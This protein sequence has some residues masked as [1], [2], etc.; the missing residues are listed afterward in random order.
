MINFGFMK[1]TIK[2]FLVFLSLSVHAQK[3]MLTMHEAVNGLSTELAIK[4][5]N[6]LQWT[7]TSNYYANVITQ[8]NIEA[9]QQSNPNTFDSKIVFDLL[10]LNKAIVN[11]KVDTFSKMPKI[12]WI[13]NNNFYVVQKH[14]YIS[15]T[16]KSLNNLVGS[17]LYTLPDDA[18]N[19]QIHQGS[20]NIAYTH[21]F[22]IF[23]CKK[24]EKAV[25]ITTDG[26]SNLLYGTS[27][28][29]DEFGIDHGLFWSNDGNKI[30]YYKMD[31]SMVTDYP[32]I[33]WSAV[34]AKVKN[35][36]Y[37]FAGNTSHHVT[38]YTYNLT[39]Q[40]NILM[41][42]GEPADQ[43]LTCVTWSPDDANIYIGV[44]NREQNYLKL[45]KY[46][47]DDGVFQKIVVEERNDKYVEP[48]H[49]LYFYNHKNDQF[50]WWSQRD[51]FM[52]LYLVT[53]TNGSAKQITS[54]KWIV[55]DIAGYNALT[56]EILF[57]GTKDGAQEKNVY[58]V[59]L[60]DQ[61]I[62]KLNRNGGWHN[63]V[64]CNDASFV[65]DNYSNVVEPRT[66][67][68][69]ATNTDVEHR[70][71]TAKNTLAD[72][73]LAIVKPVSFKTNDDTKLYG[74]LMLP[75]DFDSKKKYPVIVYLYNGP[76]VQL[77]INKFPASGNLWFDY[78]TQ[79]G[80]I[81][82]EMD[83][84]GSGNRG[85]EFESITHNQLGTVEMQDQLLGIEYLKNLPYVDSTK[86]GI[87]VWS[88]GGFMTTSFM[89]RYPE[90]FKCAVAGGPVMD[91]SKYEIMYTERYMGTPQKNYDGYNINN[92]L[93]KTTN[94]KGKLLIIHGTDDET[95]V[96][97]HSQLFLKNCIDNNVQVD[98]FDYPGYQHNVRGKDREHLMQKITNYFDLYLK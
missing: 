28:H 71:L 54:G 37:P 63:V 72:Y 60:G 26:N 32:I 86:M 45:N 35:I 50:I 52:H 30:A 22:N 13:D 31:Q 20:L 44:L 33:D 95:V 19:I 57:T 68:L 41:Q 62:R 55:N 40:K 98:Y 6:Q 92:L 77:V 66:I 3:K 85:F 49:P 38:L 9:V 39:S 84:R 80:Y 46:G 36:K 43:Y 97:Q 79:H 12:N 53:E 78:M 29:R 74:R 64:A 17:I 96:W 90:L 25:Q 15:I 58:A 83:G 69:L 18:D 48:Q 2:V 7:G 51:G 27:V 82:F 59:D 47:A 94:L 11:L 91:W 4:N 81:V 75:A 65:L 42:T 16:I 14:Q 73:A 61:Q 21:D 76:H 67:E 70:I 34:P 24:N 1:N 8:N 93:T 88:F 87:H 10:D 89:L 5:L 56:N 23:I